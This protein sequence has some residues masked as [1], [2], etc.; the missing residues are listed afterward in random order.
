MDSTT[1][2]YVAL[3]QRVNNFN[4][5]PAPAKCGESKFMD[6]VQHIDSAIVTLIDHGWQF[7]RTEYTIHDTYY[8]TATH[9]ILGRAVGR[10][11]TAVLAEVRLI[12][13]CITERK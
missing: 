7:E 6:T 3:V 1:G 4:M 5:P 9:S 13:D 10:G 8:A 12:A 11:K 2:R